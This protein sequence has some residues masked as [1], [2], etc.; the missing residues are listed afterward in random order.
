MSILDVTQDIETNVIIPLANLFKS[1]DPVTNKAF[2]IKPIIIKLLAS[3]HFY[4]I[5]NIGSIIKS[6]AEFTIGTLRFLNFPVP[7]INTSL[8]I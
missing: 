1:I 6:S 3:E 4:D 5:A 7:L 8:R 2:E